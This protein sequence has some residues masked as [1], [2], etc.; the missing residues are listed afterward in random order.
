MH[1]HMYTVIGPCTYVI[2]GIDICFSIYQNLDHV[3][4]SIL[5]GADE[6]CL[7]ILSPHHTGGDC[8]NERGGAFK[9]SVQIKRQEGSLQWLRLLLSLASRNFKLSC[10]MHWG[11]SKVSCEG[12]CALCTE[13][14][15]A[16]FIISD[17]CCK[18]A[19]LLKLCIMSIVGA[20]AY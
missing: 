19:F 16:I 9:A 14:S 4:I 1:T 10:C 12:T 7:S 15:D 18:I 8:Q 5:T 20:C 13:N 2:L 11:D 3:N 6:G 17:K